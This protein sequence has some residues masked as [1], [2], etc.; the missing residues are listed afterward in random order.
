MT[1]VFRQRIDHPAA[2]KSTEVTGKQAFQRQLTAK[3]LRGFDTLLE[4]TVRLAPHE[5]TR[6]DFDE[7]QINR[8]GEEL[9]REIMEGRGMAIL[10]GITREKYSDEQMERIYFGL[11]THLGVA[12]E[13][14]AQGDKLGYVREEESDHVS[15]GYRSSAE[16]HMHTDSYE[17]VGLM[18]VQKAVSGGF[19]GMVS[20]LA[21]H[22]EI[23]RT[24]PE[25][26]EPLYRGFHYA[27]PE[28]RFSANPITDGMIPVFCNVNGK[29]SCNYASSFMRNAAEQ[30]KV[31]L[32]AGLGEGLDYFDDIASRDDFAL[33]FMLEPGE[34]LLWHN[35]LYLHSRTEFK[36]SP[37]QKRLLLRLWMDVPDG[38]PVDPAVHER[39]AAYKR[40]YA[41]K[42]AKK[43]RA[44]TKELQ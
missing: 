40:S 4:A 10:T 9:K 14:S 37:T 2:W 7:P 16:L 22:N 25:L 11:G 27:I 44:K 1:P 19:S 24:R 33:R 15:R 29:V 18:C 30:M 34:I 20:T 42:K 28:V 5:V 3:Q 41:E 31:A 21:I 38:R 23:L 12:A 39:A 8:L 32:P 6:R 13:Q 36:N 35:F 26:L 43:N 17:M